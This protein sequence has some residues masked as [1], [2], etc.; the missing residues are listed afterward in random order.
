MTKA[1]A[2][3]VEGNM[4]DVELT[5]LEDYQQVVG[6]WIEPVSIP[7]LGTMYVNEEGKLRNLPTNE[8]ATKLARHFDL[9]L[10][11]DDIRGDVV[12]V[13]P[14]RKG[15]DSDVLPELLSRVVDLGGIAP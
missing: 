6:G 3:G 9:I 15:D 4:L 5:K 14:N 2:L 13:G 8:V 1:I 10:E 11:W 12:L 7:T